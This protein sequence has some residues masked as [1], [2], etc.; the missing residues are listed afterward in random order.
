MISLKITGILYLIPYQALRK[1]AL[2]W[3]ADPE[4]QWLVNGIKTAYS[5]EQVK[6]MYDWQ[7]AHGDLYYIEYG[8][9]DR[10]T[11]GDVWI[12]DTDFAI[13]IAPDYQGQGVGTAVVQFFKER[14]AQMRVQEVYSYNKGSQRLFEQAGFRKLVNGTNYSYFFQR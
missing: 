11:I 2:A 12:C 5:V 13:V 9:K 14:S 6:Q 7:K 3:Y 4:I 8:E 1:E 10:Q